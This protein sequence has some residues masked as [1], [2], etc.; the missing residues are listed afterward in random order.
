[1]VRAEE[2]EVVDRIASQNRNDDDG[3]EDRRAL[4]ENAVNKRYE[5][6]LCIS[7]VMERHGRKVGHN[8]QKAIGCVGRTI[9]DL[10]DAL[11]MVM[12]L[13]G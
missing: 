6:G 2:A 10:W 13:G 1:M 8:E 11:P 4:V 5:T 12:S 7:I 3:N 9:S